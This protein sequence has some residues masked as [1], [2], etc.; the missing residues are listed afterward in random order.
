MLRLPHHNRYPYSPIEKRPVYA[1]PEGKKLAFY[2]AIN[3]EQFAFM[4]GFGVD[5]LSGVAAR[6]TQRNFAWRDYGLRV[7]IWR[8][9]AML[10]EFGLPATILINSL[11]C[12]NFPEIVAKII[13]RGDDVC[14]HGRSNAEMLLDVWEH[15][16]A[17]IMAEATEVLKKTFG[18][19]PGGWMGP[20][21][22]ETRSTPD[23]LV[24]AGYTYSLGWP[25]DDQPIWMKT[26]AGKLLS[27][28]YPMELNDLGT[29]VIRDQ[30]GR[31]FADMVVD[32]FDE[33]IRQSDEQ[34]LVM[35]VSLHP[36][37]CAQP[38][39]LGPLRNAISH[40]ISHPL[41]KERVWF[42]TAG[43]IATHCIALP[44]GVIPEG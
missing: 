9:F 26:R 38:F 11:V 23:L 37:I 36:F 16:E 42:T 40:C 43:Q 32:Q 17:R 29:N 8:L 21:A 4:A 25:V 10:K 39:R 34:P 6:Q 15:D 20:G 19:H 22:A 3:I 28:P 14:G 7:G 30:S 31:E 44:A 5:P 12:E 35:A 24:E 1:W 18:V 2:L 13:E 41:T 27:V 33:L